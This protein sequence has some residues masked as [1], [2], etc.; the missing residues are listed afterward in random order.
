ML[1]I[2]K[3]NYTVLTIIATEMKKHRKSHNGIH[4]D[5]NKVIR[6]CNI[7]IDEIYIRNRKIIISANAWLRP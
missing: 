7:R 1:V 2:K 4:N 5:N 3:I 6:I